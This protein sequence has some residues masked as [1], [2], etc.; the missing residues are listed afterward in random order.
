MAQSQKVTTPLN[1]YGIFRRLL[2]SCKF[3]FPLLNDYRRG[4]YRDVS[5]T[6]IVA[7]VV[8]IIYIICPI[9]LLSDFI[10]GLGQIDDAVVFALFLYLIE[11][12][13]MKYQEWKTR[14]EWRKT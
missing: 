11:K 8:T 12:D 1:K 13:L 2:A 10:P 7:F 9:D 14:K 4:N 5:F 6:T 3:L